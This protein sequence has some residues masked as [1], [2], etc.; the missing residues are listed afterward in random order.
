M[1]FTDQAVS[2]EQSIMGAARVSGLA[3]VVIILSLT[4]CLSSL[5][6]A[7]DYIVLPSVMAFL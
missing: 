1:T 7:H 6:R 3:K 4:S 5:V 2:E